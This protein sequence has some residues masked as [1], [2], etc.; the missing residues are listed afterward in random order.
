MLAKIIIL[1]NYKID[2]Y[3]QQILSLFLQKEK[4]HLFV[5]KI[6]L[7]KLSIWLT[8]N[9][10]KTIYHYDNIASEFS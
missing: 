4:I 10:I 3:N 6:R 7:L 1:K 8:T 5:L 2:P 9:R